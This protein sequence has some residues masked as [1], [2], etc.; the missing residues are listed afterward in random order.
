MTGVT[1]ADDTAGRWIRAHADGPTLG[2][3]LGAGAEVT[4][5]DVGLDPAGTRLRIRYPSGSVPVALRLRGAFNVSNALAAFAAAYAAGTPPE[6][7]AKGLASVSAV[8]GRLE[9]VDEG[10][11]FQVL[12]DYA[13]TP[14]ALARALEA[15]RAFGPKR[16]HCVFGC[17]GDRDRGKRPQMGAVAVRL[18][19]R[20][21]ITSD[22]PRSEDPAAIIREI[23][24]GVGAAPN[25]VTIV[26]RAEAIASAVAACDAGDALLIAGKGHETYQILGDRTIDFDDRE[27]ARRALRAREGIR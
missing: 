15:V 14:D 4:A 3:G 20:V 21:T 17:G 16:L 24:A 6:T 11:P 22:N 5:T 23:V 7:I 25:V 9:P 18:A 1:N 26:D 8:P 19:D 27:A 13:H 10:Q 2:F 12:V